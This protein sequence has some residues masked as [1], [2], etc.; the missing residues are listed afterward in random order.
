MQA[1]FQRISIHSNTNPGCYCTHSVRSPM[2]LLR[3]STTR[4]TSLFTSTDTL[5]FE[6]PCDFLQKK[7]RSNNT[8]QESGRAGWIAQHKL[9]NSWAR[10]ICCL[11]YI[12][13]T[14]IWGVDM[15]ANYVFPSTNPDRGLSS[16]SSTAA[17]W[18]AVVSDKE[19]EG[20]GH[21]KSGMQC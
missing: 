7:E 10:S 4:Q 15:W 20:R 3:G 14:A 2:V 21:Q 9:Q 5:C 1:F 13:R 6:D 18:G 8:R 12:Q 16:P 19:Q 17:T 11:S